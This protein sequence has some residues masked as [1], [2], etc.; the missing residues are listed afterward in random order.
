MSAGSSI[1]VCEF[2]FGIFRI[3]I[4]FRCGQRICCALSN[5]RSL[6]LTFKHLENKES[7]PCC[8]MTLR[9]TV[10]LPL[11][12]V[13]VVENSFIGSAAKSR[14]SASGPQNSQTSATKAK[15]A[16]RIFKQKCT[17]CHGQDGAGTNYGQ[18]IG[19]TN[20]SDSEWQ[21]RVDDKLIVNSI[22]HGR[23]Q[24]PAFGEK[25]TEERITSLMLYV[26]TLRKCPV[27]RLIRKSN[28]E[29]TILKNLTRF[30]FTC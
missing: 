25:L 16:R 6:L 17:K 18:I 28:F 30:L 21:Q 15:D 7:Q 9:L 3:I 26:R 1:R 13:L 5:L 8:P 27:R 14:A 20:L 2:P 24:M 19:A 4:D 10:I 11:I 12:L 29:K 23:G 22:T